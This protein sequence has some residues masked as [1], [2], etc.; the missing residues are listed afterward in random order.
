MLLEIK[1]RAADT[2]K[3]QWLTLAI[4]EVEQARAALSTSDASGANGLLHEAED[5]FSAYLS[6][7][8]AKATFIGGPDGGVEQ[9]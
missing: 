1:S 5:H 2:P 8:R 4:A 3:K 7:K 9:T 6:G